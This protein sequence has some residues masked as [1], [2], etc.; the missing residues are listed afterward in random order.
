LTFAVELPIDHQA[1]PHAQLS[2]RAESK[3]GRR[4]GAVLLTN[5]HSGG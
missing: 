5:P 4:L 1:N 3:Y 2:V